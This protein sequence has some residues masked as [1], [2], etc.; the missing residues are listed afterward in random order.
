MKTLPLLAIVLL[1]SLPLACKSKPSAAE[2]VPCTCGTSMG[3]LEGCAHPLCV[4]GKTNP[5][6]P[7]CVCGS[8]EIPKAKQ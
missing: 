3:D 5:D 4:A 8:I 2:T 1:A 7:S 6:N